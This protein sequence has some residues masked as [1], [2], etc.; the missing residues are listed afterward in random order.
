MAK[1]IFTNVIGS[2]VFDK[3]LRVID[4]TIF[5]SIEQY[6]NKRQFEEKLRKKHNAVDI[7]E[8]KI[9]KVLLLFKERKYFAHFYK[10]NLALTKEKIRDSVGDDTLIVQ[11]INNIDDISKAIN[12][13]VK[14]LRDW[15][16]FYNPEFSESVEN[17]ETFVELLLKKSKEEL[18]TEIKIRK[19]E[20][21]GKDLAKADVEPMLNLAEG[22]S[23]LFNLRKKQEA[24]LEKVMKRA[25][26]NLTEVAG[27]LI[28]A[29]LIEAAGNL[30]H[31]ALMPSSVIQVL[32][33]EKALFRHL[34]N[35]K[36]LPPKFGLIFAHKLI[37][38][39]MQEAG[40]AAR[41]LA[42]KISIAVRV[43]YFKGGFVGDKLKGELE[44]K[45]Q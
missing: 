40:K 23:Q 1:Y 42:D 35:K 2:F 11:A 7:D 43:D 36:N 10:T 45:F 4:K 37:Q 6:K 44:E 16:G 18:L 39:N 12:I 17:H 31:L 29:R 21:M 13:L 15:Y 14:R 22:I 33:A 26:P 38:N 8:G 32:G 3:Q 19:E 27:V 28:G 25:C 9:A 20:S 24:Y 34:R 30:R 5:K 41:A